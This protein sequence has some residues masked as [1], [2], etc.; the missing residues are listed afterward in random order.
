MVANPE[1][2]DETIALDLERWLNSDPE[3][4]AQQ[5]E[6]DTAVTPKT[7]GPPPAAAPDDPGP[8]DPR[9]STP[10]GVPDDVLQRVQAAIANWDIEIV[11]TK[12]R[13]WGQT[14]RGGEDTLRLRLVTTLAPEV[15]KANPAATDLF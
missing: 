6:L 11:K 9:E 13:E 8:Q 5:A 1:A 10:G 2:S 15:A 14:T 3:N 7:D 12:L 4:A